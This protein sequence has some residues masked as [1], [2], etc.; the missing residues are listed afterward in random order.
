MGGVTFGSLPGQ[1]AGD[2]G[3]LSPT[4]RKKGKKLPRGLLWP[5]RSLFF[6]TE[7]TILFLA[8]FFEYFFAVLCSVLH[9]TNI[10]KKLDST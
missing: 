3:G 6:G 4:R 8:S 7:L 10:Y 1:M 5:V 2:G 9:V